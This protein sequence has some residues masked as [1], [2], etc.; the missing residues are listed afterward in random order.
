MLDDY[1]RTGLVYRWALVSGEPRCIEDAIPASDPGAPIALGRNGVVRTLCDSADALA[2]ALAVSEPTNGEP[3]TVS[4]WDASDDLDENG[5]SVMVETQSPNPA[6]ALAPRMIDVTDPETGAVT[7]E[8]N[9]AWEAWDA[10]QPVIAGAPALAR[11]VLRL[12][13]ATG[14]DEDDAAVTSALDA[15]AP[16]AIPQVVPVQV[17]L[18]QARAILGQQGMLEGADA[19]VQA[20]GD[21]LLQAVWQYGNFI[22]RASPGVAALGAILKIS[23]AQIDGLFIAADALTA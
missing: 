12:R 21:P 10:A 9:P 1:T 17:A 13:A 2:S 19:A 4:V 23:S 7:N 6:F 11:A 5:A 3:E 16:V 15:A 8:A 20:S 14:F 22:T 18:W